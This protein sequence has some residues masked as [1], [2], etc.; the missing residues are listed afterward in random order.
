M[1][2]ECI[3]IWTLY[4]FCFTKN[5]KSLGFTK[6]CKSLDFTKNFKSL[7]FT[8]NCKSLDLTKN[9]KSLGFTKNCKSLGFTKNYKSYCKITKVHSWHLDGW[10]F[11]NKVVSEWFAFIY[12]T[13]IPTISWW[14]QLADAQ[15]FI[16]A[17]A[18]S[19]KQTVSLQ[20]NLILCHW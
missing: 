4:T 11:S 5:C 7:G 9:F 13:I 19:Q 10:P 1:H 6:N 2:F 16:P 12:S 14:F 20:K 3:C 8:K 17:N 18:L 15:M